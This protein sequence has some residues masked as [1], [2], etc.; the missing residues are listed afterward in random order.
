MKKRTHRR[1]IFRDNQAEIIIKKLSSPMG[2]FI[3]REKILFF[4]KLCRG[5]RHSF[6]EN[7]REF[8]Q[9]CNFH[10]IWSLDLSP[11]Q[12][13]NIKY[14]QKRSKPIYC[15]NIMSQSLSHSSSEIA[16]S[17]RGKQQWSNSINIPIQK[18]PSDTQKLMYMKISQPKSKKP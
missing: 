5:L 9:V 1:K 8:R 18:P 15:L 6:M 2:F 12:V 11:T 7:D 10:K 14:S 3:K 4:N 16:T 17:K 13:N